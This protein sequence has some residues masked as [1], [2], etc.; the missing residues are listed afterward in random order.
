MTD[1]IYLVNPPNPL[2]MKGFPGSLLSLDL[3]VRKH[4]PN[5]VSTIINEEETTTEYLRESLERKLTQAPEDSYFGIT[6]TTA[7]YQDA[8]ETARVLRE[9]KPNSTIVLGG[10]H[11]DGQEQVI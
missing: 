11:V 9:I 2:N 4:C 5:I 8:L 6:C 7:T 10:H 1:R 3:W